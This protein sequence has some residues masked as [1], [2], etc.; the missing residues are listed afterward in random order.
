MAQNSAPFNFRRLFD[1]Q[2]VY[3][4]SR[5][6]RDF[7][8]FYTACIA[9][10]TYLYDLYLYKK[11]ITLPSHRNREDDIQDAV[12]RFIMR[13]QRK[14]HYRVRK[15]FRGALNLEVIYLF[16]FHARQTEDAFYSNRVELIE[17]ITADEEY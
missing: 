13:Y 5:T 4:E 17:Q 11:R 1:L 9:G 16:L 12:T 15:S 10:V 7:A 14:P 6:D 2:A 8:E 3:V